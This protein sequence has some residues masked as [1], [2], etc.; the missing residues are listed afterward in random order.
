MQDAK[1][2]QKQLR[3]TTGG[4]NRY[5]KDV[6]SYQKELKMQE[7][8]LEKF[9]AEGADEYKIKKA[10]E[11]IEE[12]IQVTEQ[13]KGKLKTQLEKV[14][15]LVDTAE[16]FPETK[17]SEQWTKTQESIKDVQEFMTTF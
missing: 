3:I 11:L 10:K 4:L 8:K 7:E 17:E 2:H 13:L 16:I 12:T 9:V 5:K 6:I 14:Q 1:N 15:D